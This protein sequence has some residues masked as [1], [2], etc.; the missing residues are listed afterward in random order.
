MAPASSYSR[1]LTT[2]VL[3][4]EGVRLNAR[5][6]SAPEYPN[7]SIART[8]KIDL[9]RDTFLPL[10]GKVNML[11]SRSKYPATISRTFSKELIYVCFGTD[12][13]GAGGDD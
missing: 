13:H 3:T 12:V 8:Q 9:A 11:E 4:A 10:P 6:T 1:P 5:A 7:W 2:D